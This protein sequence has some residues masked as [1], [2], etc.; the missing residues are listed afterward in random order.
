MG[1]DGLEVL[2]RYYLF[3]EEL[4]ATDGYTGQMF[5]VAILFREA[6]EEKAVRENFINDVRKCKHKVWLR[7][8]EGIVALAFFGGAVFAAYFRS[9]RVPTG[10]G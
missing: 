2:E 4:K 6:S 8:I 9:G 7:I 3:T 10:C 5:P 1:E